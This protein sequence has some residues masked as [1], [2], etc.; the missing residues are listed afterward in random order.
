MTHHTLLSKLASYKGCKVNDAIDAIESIA[1]AHQY[2]VLIQGH[3]A[4]P[5]IDYDPRQLNVQT[6]EDGTILGFTI[7]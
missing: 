3:D 5:N 6:R 2:A 4:P 7:G 1:H